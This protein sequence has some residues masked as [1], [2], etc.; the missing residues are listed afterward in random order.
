MCLYVYECA[1]L[2]RWVYFL[3]YVSCIS[4]FLPIYCAL[5]VVFLLSLFVKQHWIY[6]CDIK[7]SVVLS[8]VPHGKHLSSMNTNHECQKAQDTVK[9]DTGLPITR[10]FHC[11]RPFSG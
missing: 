2:E 5:V 3:C 1:L 11:C 9:D 4:F 7:L 8:P 6:H 10:R